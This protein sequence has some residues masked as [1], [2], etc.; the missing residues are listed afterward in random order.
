MEELI[1]MFKALMENLFFWRIVA[2]IMFLV[3]LGL[4]SFLLYRPSRY[5]IKRLKRFSRLRKAQKSFLKS[6]MNLDRELFE[7]HQKELERLAILEL[8]EKRVEPIRNLLAL[9]EK[10]GRRY[11]EEFNKNFKKLIK[12][13]REFAIDVYVLT[14]AGLSVPT[15]IKDPL[16][17]RALRE[18]KETKEGKKEKGRK[19]EKREL[20][21]EEK[22]K[23][24]KAK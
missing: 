23:E 22:P 11:P 20:K 12:L 14:L 18:L 19:E 1:S 13:K 7:K 10:D 9:L 17:E 3:I 6:G 5:S 4:I 24:E 8:A 16:Y 2:G 15:S 21:V